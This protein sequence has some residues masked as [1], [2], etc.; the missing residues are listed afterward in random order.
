MQASR[1]AQYRMPLLCGLRILNDGQSA[2]ALSRILPKPVAEDSPDSSYQRFPRLDRVPMSR[3]AST[4]Q[5]PR[6]PIAT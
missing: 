3:S 6:T 5:G 2:A 4:S 1:S